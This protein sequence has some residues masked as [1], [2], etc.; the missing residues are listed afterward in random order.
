MNKKHKWENEANDN[1][2]YYQFDRTDLVKDA[3]AK[4]KKEQNKKDM[5]YFRSKMLPK[6]R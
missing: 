6:N 1:M 4:I 2:D 5:D 3:A